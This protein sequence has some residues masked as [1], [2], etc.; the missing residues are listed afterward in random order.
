M[1]EPHLTEADRA[2]LRANY[3]TLNE[4][5][6]DRD[7]DPAEIRLLIDRG[8][9]P[10]PSYIVDG[11]GMFPEDYFHLYDEAGGCDGLRNLFE[12]RYRIAAIP[13]PDLATREAIDSAWR[14]FLGGV[15]GQCLRNVTPETIVRKRALVNSLCKL[16]GL[17]RPRQE[18]WRQRLRDEVAEL[19]QIE[20]E[21]APDYDRAE[22]WNERPPSRDLLIDVARRRFP[23]VF[24]GED[25]ERG[26][27]TV[28]SSPAALTPR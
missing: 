24:D 6:A 10:K 18:E 28:E 5:C 9:L 16:I 27:A 2:Y 17:P 8:L 19:D 25:R 11:V 1:I 7:E 20:R 26:R 23:E 21:F 22:E 13:H 3:S 15:W 14:A 4:L 12:E